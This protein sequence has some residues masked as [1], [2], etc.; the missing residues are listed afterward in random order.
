MPIYIYYTKIMIYYLDIFGIYLYI[1]NQ[2]KIDTG[3]SRLD[4]W[5]MTAILSS[6][7]PQATSPSLRFFP[8][9]KHGAKNG[10]NVVGILVS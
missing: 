6:R 4:F 7:F 5:R 2:Y 3:V 10:R 9:T 1:E 8:T